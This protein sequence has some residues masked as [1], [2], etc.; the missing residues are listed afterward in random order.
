MTRGRG[1]REDR[2]P[3]Q[4]D[5]MDYV[6]HRTTVD[7]I[8]A[9]PLTR[10]V[11]A[12]F[13]AGLSVRTVSAIRMMRTKHGWLINRNPAE[14]APTQA[15][16]Q[17]VKR[18][19]TAD[20]L[21]V[22]AVGQ[23]IRTVDELAAHIQLDRAK[24]EIHEP[25]ATSWDVTVRDPVTG[26]TTTVQNHRV[27][28][29]ARLK[30]GPDVREQVAAVIAGAFA[31]RRPVAVARA[32][33]GD[34]ALLQGIVIADPHVGKLAWGEATGGPNYDTGIAVAQVQAGGAALIAKGD[35]A[36]VGQRHFWLLGDYFHHDGRGMTTS[37][38]ALDYDSRG[39]K[40][41]R[42]G[43]AV[44]CDLIAASAARVPTTVYIVPGNHDAVLTWALQEILAAEFRKHKGVTI[45]PGVTATK[46][47]TH[48]RCLIGL[49]HGDRGKKR[50]PAKMAALCE[51]EWARAICRE[52]HTGHLHSRAAIVTDAGVT[53]HTH[54]SL[55]PADQWHAD[56]KF[57]TMAPR[58]MQ[59]FRYHAG[60][61]CVGTDVWSPDLHRAP[62]R[63]TATARAA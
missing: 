31:A 52:I 60:G 53:I 45:D 10:E 62:R 27:A 51:V 43:S 39:P 57:D 36:E 13:H 50:L 55:G 2:T 7:G 24:Y 20:G 28:F 59:A 8:E 56:E 22:L 9:G 6:R 48:G 4:A 23:R 29:K 32:A 49:D 34:A 33:K 63:G 41:L 46:F 37:G 14:A 35:A 11:N 25:Q 1:V 18:E 58:T 15:R 47:L 42:A 19:E 5:E 12:R 44:L 21:S 40:M 26:D 16:E 3:H 30:A 61:V 38:T 54:D 17:E